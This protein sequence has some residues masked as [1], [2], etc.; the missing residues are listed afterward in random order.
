MYVCSSKLRDVVRV[1]VFGIDS[2]IS[3]PDYAMF[4]RLDVDVYEC[5]KLT[6]DTTIKTQY[7]LKYWN[8]ITVQLKLVLWH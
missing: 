2:S 4:S 7:A 8:A 1:R 6:L 3:L 5:A